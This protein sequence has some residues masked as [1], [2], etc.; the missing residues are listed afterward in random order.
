MS[1]REGSVH[2][3]DW[4]SNILQGEKCLVLEAHSRRMSVSPPSVR[5]LRKHFLFTPASRGHPY[6][7]IGIKLVRETEQGHGSVGPNVRSFF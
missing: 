5:M 4:P 2:L 1:P 6:T 7:P 3:E